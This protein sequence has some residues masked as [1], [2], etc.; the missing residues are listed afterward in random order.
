M[1]NN[2]TQ[3]DHKINDELSSVTVTNPYF[4]FTF[5]LLVSIDQKKTKSSINQYAL[6]KVHVEK[7]ID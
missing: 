6:S 7:R 1:F 5:L 2:N 4:Q 3:R